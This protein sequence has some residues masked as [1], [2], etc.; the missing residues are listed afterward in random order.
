V[1]LKAM[2]CLIQDFFA[3]IAALLRG[4]PHGSYAILY[5][6]GN[7]AGCARGLLN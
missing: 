4:M 6:V 2:S 7:G 3:R 5:R 1:P